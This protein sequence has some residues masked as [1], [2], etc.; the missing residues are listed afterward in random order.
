M[1]KHK[2]TI[3]EEETNLLW[4]LIVI[5]A[6]AFATYLLGDAFMDESLFA[7]GFRQLSALFLFTLSFV[8]ILKI[9][10]PLYRFDLI[11]EGEMLTI[12]VY[13]GEEH[14]KNIYYNLN[15]FEELRFAPGTP[16]LSD[17]ALFDFSP[18]YHLVFKSR[19]TGKVQ[20]LIDLGRVSFTL[21]VPDIA[22]VIRFLRRHNSSIKVP[23][24][25]SA[26]VT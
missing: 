7:L 8:G 14:V 23:E 26:Y 9:T 22:E 11:V 21:K 17:D 16:S 12:E 4:G 2:L 20:K 25:Q 18:S 15:E 6:S 5:V 24:E 3:Y 10:D 19:I 1:I 13:K